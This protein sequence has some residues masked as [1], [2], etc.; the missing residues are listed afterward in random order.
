MGHWLW[1][2]PAGGKHQ[3]AWPPI[4]ND[5]ESCS[6]IGRGE[7]RIALARRCCCSLGDSLCWRRAPMLDAKGVA[8][9]VE[10]ACTRNTI[11]T[12]TNAHVT[13]HKRCITA[14]SLFGPQIFSPVTNT[15][16]F[17]SS[18]SPCHAFYVHTH[19]YREQTAERMHTHTRVGKCSVVYCGGW[20]LVCTLYTPSPLTASQRPIWSR[21]SD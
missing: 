1:F 17:S 20:Q 19:A 14:G 5:V 13:V 6:A 3:F 21:T 8:R 4:R 15:D 16:A 10:Y 11:G 7:L 9:R 2:E 18:L 12:C